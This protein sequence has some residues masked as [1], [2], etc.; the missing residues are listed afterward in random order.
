MNVNRIINTSF[1]LLVHSMSYLR[2]LFWR[3]FVKKIGSNVDIMGGV[4][5][6]SPQRLVIGNHVLINAYSIIGAQSGISIGNYVM[7]GYNVNLAT[8]NHKY[9]N[10]KLPIKKQGEYGAPISIEDDVWIGANVTILP[11][12]TIGKGAIIGANSV[13]TKNIKPYSIAAGIPA[14][15]IKYRFNKKYRSIAN[16][17]NYSSY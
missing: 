1:R 11:G 2:T 7:L 4:I 3:L 17:I 8:V 12:I 14:R 13:V 6:M 5:I 10:P 15:H 16:M 9:T